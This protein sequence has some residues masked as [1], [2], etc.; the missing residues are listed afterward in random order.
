ML[1]ND[2]SAGRFPYRGNDYLARWVGLLLK[3][4]E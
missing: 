2:A 1:D 3:G 4:T